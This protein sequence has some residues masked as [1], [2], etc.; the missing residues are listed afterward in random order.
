MK[1]VWNGEIIAESDETV[2]VDGNHYFPPDSVKTEKL[3]VS[4]TKSTCHW[5][6][7]ASYCSIRVAEQVNADAAW[8]YPEAKE[9]AAN[10]EGFYAFWN[11]VEVVE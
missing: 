7:E 10:I 8:F 3:E 9:E 6:G 1:A 4:D 11:G 5:K 2:V